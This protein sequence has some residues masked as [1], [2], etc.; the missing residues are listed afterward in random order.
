MQLLQLLPTLEALDTQ[1]FRWINNHY[2][3]VFDWVLWIASQHWSQAIVLAAVC[4]FIIVRK[5]ASRWWL[6]LIGVALCFLVS[7]QISTHLFKEV[8]QRLRPCHALDEV[9]MFRTHCGGNYGFVSSHA[10]NCFTVTLFLGLLAK[11]NIR[12]PYP[13]IILIVW[14]LI[15]CYSRPYLGKHYP[16]DVICGALLGIIVGILIYYAYLWA[17]KKLDKRN[18]VA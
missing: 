8:F 16:G 14:S 5:G 17:E 4:I 10:A 12:T 6:L 2:N 18:S 9:R 3:P 15:V 13:L 7:D 11:R 1:A